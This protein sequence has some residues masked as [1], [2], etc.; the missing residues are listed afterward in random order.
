MTS[1]RPVPASP[2]GAAPLVALLT[3]CVARVD[4]DG[5]F[6]GSG[7]F[8]TPTEVLTCA[9]VIHGGG[10]VSVAVGLADEADEAITRCAE[11]STSWDR[12]SRAVHLTEL[13]AIRPDLASGRPAALDHGGIR[14]E[15]FLSFP[16]PGRR[17]RTRS[18]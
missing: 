1:P 7:F 18:G 2:S 15:P 17:R 9:H 12:R 4:C 8:V 6:R 10:A 13:T 16:H 11:A 5:G 3:R 14:E